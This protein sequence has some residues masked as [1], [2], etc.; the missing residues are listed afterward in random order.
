MMKRFVWTVFIFA[1]AMT[2]A[3]SSA[4]AAIVNFLGNPGFE[5]S[6][7]GASNWNN[8]A[9]RGISNPTI[10]GAPEGSHVLRLDE[11]TTVA[12][13]FVG[14]FTFQVGTVKEG[15]LVAFSGLVRANSLDA[16][17]EGQLRIEFQT[18]AGVL[19]SASN[20][21]VSAVS[22]NFSRVVVSGTAPTSTA[23]VAFVIRIQPSN[24]G[25]GSQVDFDDVKGTTNG[26]PVILETGT[27]GGVQ[28]PGDI[29][30]ISTRLQNTSAASVGPVEVVTTFT[31]G[32]S[33]HTGQAS[34]DGHPVNQHEGSVVFEIGTLPAGQD[35]AF[36]FAVLLSS[37]VLPGKRYEVTL[38]AR[39]AGS[40]AAL[41]DP[42]RIVIDVEPDP[43]FSMGT[44]IGKVFNDTNGNTVQDP[45]EKGVPN[46]RIAT[47]QGIVVY[48]DGYGKYHI[49]QIT[50]GRHVVKVDYHSLPDGTQFVTEESYVAKITDGLLA[51]VNFAVKLPDEAVPEEY[52]G[53]L[54]MNVIQELD[55][56]KPELS[57]EMDPDIVKTGQGM[58]EREIRFLLHTNYG[59]LIKEWRIE[60]RDEMGKEVWSGVGKGAPPSAVLWDGKDNAGIMIQP[61]DYALRLVAVDKDDKEDWTALQFFRVQSKLKPWENVPENR[62]FASVGYFNLMADGKRSIPFAGKTAVRV[63][64]KTPV[65]NQVLVNRQPVAVNPDGTFE[66]GMFLADG[67]QKIEVTTTTEEGESLSVQKEIQIKDNYLF[68]VGLGEDQMGFNQFKGNIESV[69]NAEK[70]RDGFY[71]DGR[72]S[73]YLKGKV[74]GKFLVTSH[75]DSDDASRRSKLFTSLDPDAYYPVYGDKSELDFS[76]NDTQGKFYVL[77]EKDRSFIKWGSFNTDFTD[78]ELATHNRTGS[79]GK[80]HFETVGTTRYGDAK[81]GFSGFHTDQKQL[82]DH[83][84]FFGTGGSLYY[85]RNKRVIEGS[86]KLRVETRDKLSGVVLSKQDFISGTDYEID[87]DQGR[88]I[89][90]KPLSSI[91]GGNTLIHQGILEGYSNVLIVDYEYKEQR[92][93]GYGTNGFRGFQHFGDFVK[94]GGTYIEDGHPPNN[95]NHT[96]R[97]VDTEFKISTNTKVTAEYAQSENPQLNGYS[98]ANGGLSF[99]NGGSSNL[100]GPEQ[101]RNGAYIIRAQSKPLKQLDVSGYIQKYNPFFSNADTVFSQGDVRKYGVE[102]NYRVTN[103][104]VLKYRRD[105]MHTV[106]RNDYTGTV[107]RVRYHT[108]QA[109][110]DGPEV[111]AQLEYQNVTAELPTPGRLRNSLFSVNEFNDTVGAKLGYHVTEQYMP[112]VRGQMT[113]NGGKPDN[114]AGVGLEAR[115]LQKST[116]SIEQDF[117]NVGDSTQLKFE[118]QTSERSTAYAKIAAGDDR[119]FGKA[120]QTTLGS[121]HTMDNRSRLF[122]EKEFSGYRGDNFARN[123]MGYERSFFDN[124]LGGIFTIEH[125]NIDRAKEAGVSF[126]DAPVLNHAV[127]TG[128]TYH[129]GKILEASTKWEFR[130]FRQEDLS[131]RQWLSYNNL[132]IQVTK[133]LEFFSR[134]NFSKTRDIALTNTFANFVE[135]NTGFAFR[136]VEWDRFNALTRY[137]YLNDNLPDARFGA[138]VALEEI[139]HIFALEGSYD[140][141][142]YWG[143]VEKLAYKLSEVSSSLTSAIRV[144]NYLLVNRINFHVTR[145]WDFGTEYRILTQQ[146]AGQNLRHGALVEI[147]RELFD[148]TRIGVGYNFTDFDDDLRKVNS[149]QS[150]SQGP[151]VRLTGK[152]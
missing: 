33:I 50:P 147:D 70:F 128:L 146:G 25:G 20:V 132:G 142:R 56:I 48:T 67:K 45:G 119:D 16:G 92:I 87:Y 150:F 64:G 111:L 54:A 115:V 124:R 17:D 5:N 9:N 27:T 135:M 55:R 14:V 66:T 83:N 123:M 129:E 84:E 15:D 46:V 32:L 106:K 91:S 38:L 10:A 141:N 8:D 43:L 29:T 117:G 101:G 77:V 130:K 51:K 52:K 65:K 95:R 4:Q 76:A 39:T 53:N 22:A 102:A 63:Q 81:A 151:F 62:P 44:V 3:V 140:F 82:P 103:N 2:W 94:I 143:W 131:D 152:F 116:M 125:N 71:Q 79:G 1:V 26:L 58:L 28:K 99:V 57:V 88:I 24:A 35:S 23:Q 72:V 139:A 59:N 42:V 34:L 120:I 110:Y 118:T 148:Y 40:G 96:L 12:G 7:G 6:L 74:K 13:G 149:Y 98:S 127:S 93:T 11:A 49:P 80:V 31:P 89:L 105:S 108:L 86:E 137:T 21:S 107:D 133:D 113:L 36:A 100:G 60:V 112:Y 61:G 126:P 136:P 97:G 134:F 122:T 30:M 145:K 144:Y 69:G 78:T 47:E 121:S 18:S 104:F 85:L 138:G 68:M 37:G 19:I 41:S 75:Y 90:N 73:Y 114:Q 109:S